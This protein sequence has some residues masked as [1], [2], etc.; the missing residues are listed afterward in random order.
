M[1]RQR[2]LQEFLSK[3]SKFEAR[4]GTA[5]VPN[6]R[7]KGFHRRMQ[8]MI[9]YRDDVKALRLSL[10]SH[11]STIS[12]L[13]V[14][15]TVGSITVA[16]RDRERVRCELRNKILAH[17][18]LLQDVMDGQFEVKVQLQNQSFTLDDL[19]GKADST[20]VQLWRQQVLI[21]DG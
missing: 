12:L 4:L 11:V 9:M 15:Q 5:N 1:V 14:T 13:L 10:G 6:N 18:S 2:P 19:G 17:Q 16:E 7:F 21:K 8:W 20:L 3:I